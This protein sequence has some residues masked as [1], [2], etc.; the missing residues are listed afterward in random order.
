[1]LGDGVSVGVWCV[2][3][4]AAAQSGVSKEVVLES[5]RDKADELAGFG[6]VQSPVY[7]PTLLGGEFRGNKRTAAV[8]AGWLAQLPNYACMS[9]LY[10]DT[11]IRYLF[12]HFKVMDAE[13]RMCFEQKPYAC[14]TAEV[15]AD[16]REL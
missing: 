3:C 1:M 12:S 6:W 13:R 15:G 7:E 9:E 16:A 11:K 4:A 5:I 10:E 14:P 8:M 2:R